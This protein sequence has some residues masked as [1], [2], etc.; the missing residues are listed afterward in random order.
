MK[1]T[2]THR[3]ESGPDPLRARTGQVDSLPSELLSKRPLK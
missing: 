1:P 2:A 3:V